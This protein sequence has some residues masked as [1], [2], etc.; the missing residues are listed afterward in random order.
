MV[1]RHRSIL[2]LCMAL[3]LMMTVPAGAQSTVSLSSS[4]G[5]PGDEVEVS[6]MLGNAPSATALQICIPHSPYLSYVDGSAKLNTQRVSATHSLSVS[7]KD[8]LL[9]LYVYDVSLNTF[10]EGTGAFMTFRLKLGN[11]PAS[12][13]LKPEVVLSDATGKSMSV[14][15]KGCDIKILGPKISLSETEI[16]FGSVPIRS[17]YT[18]EV[19]VS[20]TGNETLTVSEIKSGSALFKGTLASM[21]I[22]AGQKQKLTIEYSPQNE[23]NDLAD[24]I[25]VSDAANGKQTIHVSAAPF[26]VNTLSVADASG[27]SGEEVTV[28]V[29]MRNM[30][31]IVAVQCRFELPEALKY[32]EGSAV[33][34]GRASGSHQISGSQEDNKLSLYIHSATNAALSGNDGEL[35]TFKLLLDGTGGDY[36]LEPEDVLLSNI[37]GRDMTSEVGGATVR[38]AA[39]KMVCSS[40]LD[41]GR[42]PIEEI[43]KQKYTI[44]NS[45]ESPLVI[46]RIEFS[47]ESFYLSEKTLPTIAAGKSIDVEVCYRP[48]G[49]GAFSGVMQIYG[50]DPQNLMKAVEIK[51]TTYAFNE[52]ELSG[53]TDGDNPDRYVVTVSM[54]NS[55]PVVG[56]QMDIHWIPGMAPVKDA[57]SMSSRASGHKAEITKL[58]DDSYRIYIYSLGN[59]PIASGNGPVFSIIYNKVEGQDGYDQT[60]IQADNI[61]LSTADER[62]CASSPTATLTVGNSLGLMGDAN[63]DGAVNVQ[64]VICISRY[65]LGET[66][67]SDIVV[68]MADIDQDQHITAADLLG[69]IHIIFNDNKQ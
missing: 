34:S 33:L 22:A 37:S 6:V 69:V 3:S 35:F 65:L 13:A 48:S 17:T 42:I 12:Y 30:E 29:S 44:T 11:E 24:I 1:H 68:S 66:D 25:L 57:I 8:D 27:Q 60:V 52:I 32:V 61:I 53:K 2:I 64:D 16:D 45:G 20:N 39:P 31:S 28:H 56:L 43:L 26:S 55:L 38:I 4:S 10:I 15:V 18:K 5:H 63:N 67:S 40:E 23:G 51:G 19:F 46:Q 62:N 41:F 36:S 49:E 9:K 7:D 47:D 59:D 14:T 50:N 58:T 21:S 54:Q